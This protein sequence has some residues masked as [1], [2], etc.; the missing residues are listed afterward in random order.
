M[1]LESLKDHPGYPVLFA[2]GELADE[3][4]IKAWLVGGFVRDLLLGKQSNDIDIM[5]VGSGVDFAKKVHTRFPDAKTAY[6]KNFGTASVK[7]NQELEL[8]F[9]GARKESYRRGSRK[10]IVEDGS[11]EDDLSRR[12]FTVNALALSLNSTS[13]AELEDHFGGLADMDKGVLR[14]PLDPIQTYSDDPLRMLRAA[15]FAAQLNFRIEKESLEAMSSQAERIQIVSQERITEELNKML[16][17]DKPSIGF[18]ILFDTGL[19]QL[20]FP[21]LCD[22]HGVDVKNGIA[23]KDNFYH[24]L[25]VVDNL[26]PMSD[27]LWLRWAALLHDIGKPASKRFD[28]KI[29]WT[30][31]GHEVIGARMCQPI[32]KKLRLPLNDKF[33]Y[34]RKLVHLHLRPIALMGEVGDSAVRRLLVDAGN[35]IEDLLTLCRADITSKNRH[36]VKKIL[37]GFDKVEKKI[38]DVE[39]RDQLRNWKP[40]VSGEDIMNYFG[41]RPSPIVGEIKNNIREAILNGDIPNERD[42]AFELMK[43]LGRNKG[44]IKNDD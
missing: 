9:V 19:L 11:L 6:F 29:G 15:R 3:E 20:I 30:F 13:F 37:K 28:E 41:V 21:E 12:D 36:K 2:I 33:K 7:I 17:T 39:E 4:G 10:P 34:V 1:R 26:A 31:H 27:D 16:L 32:F 40:P 18:R 35:D 38:R 22:L 14:T 8:E 44:L 42:A 43:E 23:H 5:V 24:S 25:K